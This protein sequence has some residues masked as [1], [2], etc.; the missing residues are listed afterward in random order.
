[1]NIGRVHWI[2]GDLEKVQTHEPEALSRA[3]A[4]Y[5][6]ALSFG[7]A[8]KPVE[9]SIRESKASVLI[10][11]GC[12]RANEKEIERAL[13]DKLEALSEEGR[14]LESIEIY[15]PLAQL[16]LQKGEVAKALSVLEIAA[17]DA[18]IAINKFE[19]DA[20][21][22]TYGDRLI[23]LFNRLGSLYAGQGSALETLNAIE[24]FRC[25]RL[26]VA[27]SDSDISENRLADALRVLNA[28]MLNT[29]SSNSVTELP[30]SS[31]FIGK[32]SDYLIGHE[33]TAYLSIAFEH[34]EVVMVLAPLNFANGPIV[35]SYRI[36][37]AC[38]RATTV[39]RGRNPLFP[40][41]P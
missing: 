22:R 25:C 35:K 19:T 2:I 6:D 8:M 9:K 31:E 28:R 32:I 21:L 15:E 7:P 27:L 1:M 29:A 11:M 3:L 40:H 23:S 39:I 13:S 38:C 24:A 4:K 33:L 17:S 41:F 30:N 14:F 12:S 10:R 5:D 16:F 20:M 26:S 34:S 36:D 37:R 18:M